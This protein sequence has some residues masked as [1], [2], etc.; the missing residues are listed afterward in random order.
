MRIDER[1][2]PISPRVDGTGGVRNE[3]GAAQGLVVAGEDRVEVSSTARTLA[4]LRTKLAP[5]DGV[6]EGTVARLR[7]QVESGQYQ[8]DLQAVARNLIREVVAPL[9]A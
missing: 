8:P 9:V 1:S 4:V 3:G 2:G 6:R 5:F 7:D